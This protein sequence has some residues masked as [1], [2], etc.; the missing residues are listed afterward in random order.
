[1]EPDIKVDETEEFYLVKAELPGI[2]R[3]HVELQVDE[4][5]LS[6]TGSVREEQGE[7]LMH[8]RAGRFFYRT[9]LPRDIDT[10]KGPGH[11]ER[12]D[13]DDSPPE[14]KTGDP[15]RAG[16]DSLA[17]PPHLALA[18]RRLPGPGTQTG[19]P[20]GRM[21]PAGADVAGVAVVLLAADAVMAVLTGVPP[22]GG[23]RHPARRAARL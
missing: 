7:H 12:G 16:R 19:R 21:P 3:D 9:V 5:S 14:D 8:R 10:D 17:G 4:H 18:G 15:P 22:G 20:G 2:T 6:N 23:C 13:P 11:H 1:V